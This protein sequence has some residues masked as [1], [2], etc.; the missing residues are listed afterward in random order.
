MH[1]KDAIRPMSDPEIHSRMTA[2]WSFRTARLLVRSNPSNIACV[3]LP[4]PVISRDW[5]TFVAYL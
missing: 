3:L 4:G 2:A 1:G 5:P